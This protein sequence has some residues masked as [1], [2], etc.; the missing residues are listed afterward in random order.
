MNKGVTKMHEMEVRVSRGGT[1][2]IKVSDPVATAF[3]EF[4]LIGPHDVDRFELLGDGA[5]IMSLDDWELIEYV[6]GTEC[7][8][9]VVPPFPAEQW[10][11]DVVTL[12]VGYGDTPGTFI[13]CT[14][15][16]ALN[17]GRLYAYDHGDR[18][19]V[20]REQFRTEQVLYEAFAARRHKYSVPPH[21]CGPVLRGE[22]GPYAAVETP[23]SAMNVEYGFE[24]LR[25]GSETKYLILEYRRRWVPVS[26]IPALPLAT[27]LMRH[28][29]VLSERGPEIETETD[30][31]DDDEEDDF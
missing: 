2:R 16:K 20:V 24:E 7:L 6:P 4:G 12:K 18:I 9:I 30:D 3:N 29:G 22:G 31:D 25:R 23:V 10:R 1:A 8:N 17:W 14:I 27:G 15:P 13:T 28:E 19:F 21:V 11:H 26:S 5:W